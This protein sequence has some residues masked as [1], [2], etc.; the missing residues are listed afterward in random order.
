V[1]N[2]HSD[3]T[4]GVVAGSVRLLDRVRPQI[5]MLGACLDPAAAF[6]LERGLKTLVLRVERQNATA[7]AGAEALER[8][9][10]VA[11]VSHPPLPSHPDEPLARRLLGGSAGMVTIRVRGG[12]RA[13]ARA[14]RALRLVRRAPTLGGVESL[15]VTASGGTPAVLDAAERRRVG[16]LP[17]TVRLS[18]G[19]E[20]PCDL[21]E[22]LDQ[23]L[24]A[25][26]RARPRV[27]RRR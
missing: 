16:I 15:A 10:A 7:L 11:A 25:A 18:L 3:V 5:E 23:A 24:R 8:H 1:L 27:G 14:V 13:A 19:V 12:D 17:G 20:D 9:P 22:D 2:G 21:L 4:A 26:H 6:L